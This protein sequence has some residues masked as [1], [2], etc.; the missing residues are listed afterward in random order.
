MNA[1]S[2]HNSP[3]DLDRGR[4]AGF[5]DYVAKTDQHALLQSLSQTLGTATGDAA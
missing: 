2:S 5:I 1:L 3:S 4:D